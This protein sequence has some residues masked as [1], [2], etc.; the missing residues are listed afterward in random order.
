MVLEWYPRALGQVVQQ[1]GSEAARGWENQEGQVPEG[2]EVNGKIFGLREK[3]RRT[4]LAVQWLRF[5]L[6]MQGERGFSVLLGAKIPHALSP[7]KT[8]KKKK[9]KNQFHNT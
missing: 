7:K 2:P 8:K 3:K 6:P 1:A 5:H 4:S 9:K